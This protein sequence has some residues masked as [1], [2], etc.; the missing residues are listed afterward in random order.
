MCLPALS[1]PSWPAPIPPEAEGAIP[2]GLSNDYLNHFSEALMLI[3]LAATD[4]DIAGDLAAWRPVTY[5]AH[6]EASR[7]RRAAAAIAAYEAL[8]EVRRGAF[9]ELTGAMNRLVRTAVLALQP[10]CEPED[11]AIVAAVTAPALH[12]LIGRAGAFLASG[13]ADLAHESE[14][15]KAQTVIDRLIERTGSGDEAAG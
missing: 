1:E 15:E 11:A 12:R 2:A 10:P 8:D 6:F 13:G 3:E 7:L 5:R 9:E 14:I 4:L